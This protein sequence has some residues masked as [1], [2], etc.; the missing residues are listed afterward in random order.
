VQYSKALEAPL[1][2]SIQRMC[3]APVPIDIVAPPTKNGDRK[4][5]IAAAFIPPFH[6]L[7]FLSIFREKQKK[8]NK[9]V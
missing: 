2:A 3:R 1:H 7:S 6:L 8:E 9:I 5:N 4:L